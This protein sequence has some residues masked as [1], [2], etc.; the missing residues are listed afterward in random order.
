MTRPTAVGVVRPSTRIPSTSARDA[1]TSS[2]FMAATPRAAGASSQAD[3]A[4]AVAHLA[5]RTLITF[6]TGE[7]RICPIDDQ[8]RS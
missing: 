3:G 5:G 4:R 7:D 2:S 8:K 6:A 1:L